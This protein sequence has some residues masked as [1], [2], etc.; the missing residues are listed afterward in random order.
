MRRLCLMLAL[1]VVVAAGTIDVPP[2]SGQPAPNSQRVK[3]L[4]FS[5]MIGVPAAFT[6]NKAADKTRGIPGGGLPWVVD[7]AQGVLRADG[8]LDI[9]V[10]GLVLDPNDPAVPGNRAG[11]NPVAQFKA[12]VS[13]L[14]VQPDGSTAVMNVSSALFP[15]SPEGDCVIRDTVDL[16]DPCIAPIVFVTSPGGSWFAATGF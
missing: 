6:G 10:R 4:E 2:V 12:V 15:A 11:T 7:R 16:P 3:I 13:C 9:R 8:D 5:T 1:A 14:T